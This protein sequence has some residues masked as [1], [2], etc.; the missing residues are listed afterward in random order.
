MLLNKVNS[1][2]DIKCFNSRAL[3][4]LCKELR[5]N[6]I[7]VTS[8]NGGHLGAN[9]GVVELTVAL[10][11]VFN[12]PKDKIIWD[13]GHQA[14][15]H[16][17]LTGRREKFITLRKE[18]GISGFTNK[19]ESYHDIFTGGH[20]STSLSMALGIE[21]ARK[22][23]KQTHKV[24]AVIGDGSLSAGMAYEAINNAGDLKNN[25]I[26]ILNDN[27]MS[28]APATG[29]LTNYLKSKFSNYTKK[30]LFKKKQLT[31]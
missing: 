31:K 13:I 11:S 29:A 3:L 30:K 21:I 15:A 25:L 5:E 9:L 8:K 14:Y 23:Q 27:G 22:F 2:K 10:H 17:I 26:V 1:P 28:I 6:I 19:E 12:T 7:N 4:K 20:S 16:K 18:N 24:I